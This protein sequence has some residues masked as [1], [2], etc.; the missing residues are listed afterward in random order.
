MYVHCTENPIYV[1]QEKEL[2]GLSPS[3]YIQV[4]VSDFYIPRIS[5]HI[6]G[7]SKI[8]RLVLEIYKSL[9]DICMKIGIGR[10]NIIILFSNNEAAEF[11]GIHKWEPDILLDSHRPFICSLPCYRSFEE[12]LRRALLSFLRDPGYLLKG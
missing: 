6:F 12:R 8:D 2:R 1:F 9:T 4:S 5:L 10:Q 7:S 3:S 11:L